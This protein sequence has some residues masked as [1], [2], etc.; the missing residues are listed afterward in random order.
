[1]IVI[2]GVE[3]IVNYTHLEKNKTSVAYVR[4]RVTKVLLD[5]LRSMKI[6]DDWRERIEKGDNWDDFRVEMLNSKEKAF[7]RN[8]RE[9]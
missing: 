7:Y 3:R 1:M 4:E 9:S 6:P 5:L 2:I 8:L